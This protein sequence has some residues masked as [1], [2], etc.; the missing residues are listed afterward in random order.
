MD[1]LEWSK[2]FEV[3]SLSR[4]YLHSLGF[5][6]EGINSLTDEDMQHIAD[7]L[8]NGM[9]IGFAEDVRFLVACEIVEKLTTGGPDEG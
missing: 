8:Q 9:L 3:L 2:K 1:S 6:L 5:S 7:D 4:L